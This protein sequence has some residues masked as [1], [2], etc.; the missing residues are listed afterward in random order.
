MALQ[1]GTATPKTMFHRAY[2]R[3]MYIV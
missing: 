3:K 1:N 2:C